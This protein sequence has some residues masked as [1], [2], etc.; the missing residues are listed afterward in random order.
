MIVAPRPSTYQ[1]CYEATDLLAVLAVGFISN[2]NVRKES[3]SQSLLCCSVRRF[4]CNGQ[5]ELDTS[6]DVEETE[7]EMPNEDEELFANEDKELFANEDGGV[8][9][10]EQCGMHS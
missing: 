7:V 8:R 6:D 2:A 10:R 1:R 4:L 3:F 9:D 5:S